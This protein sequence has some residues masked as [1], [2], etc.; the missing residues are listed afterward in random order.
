MLKVVG[1]AGKNSIIDFYNLYCNNISFKKNMHFSETTFERTLKHIL[2]LPFQHQYVVSKEIYEVSDA[3]IL[4]IT[5]EFP[6][7]T[8]FIVEDLFVENKGRNKERDD[9]FMM[10]LQWMVARDA[11]IVTNDKL[12]NYRTI[13]KE[14]KPIRV[15]RFQSGVVTE[16]NIDDIGETDFSQYRPDRVAFYFR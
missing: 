1:N 14:T 9:F 11:T 16:F 13:L 7:F 12:R 5:R 3:C 6:A 10:F 8:F 15:R 4:A 2:R